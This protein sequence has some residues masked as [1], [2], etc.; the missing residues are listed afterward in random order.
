MALNRCLASTKHSY[1]IY[2]RTV[3]RTNGAPTQ[4]G[5]PT[6]E[7]V[8][9]TGWGIVLFRWRFKSV[10][11]PGRRGFANLRMETPLA[12]TLLK[13]LHTDYIL[14]LQDVSK[15]QT[16]HGDSLLPPTAEPRWL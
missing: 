6:L 4:H 14:K 9:G 5:A 12:T 16:H 13:D 7:A 15:K 10:G 8:C 3:T 11:L 2:F 1:R